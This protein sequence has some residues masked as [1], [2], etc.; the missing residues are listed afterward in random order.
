MKSSVVSLLDKQ[1]IGRRGAVFPEQVCQAETWRRAIRANVGE[2]LRWR[3]GRSA[4][5]QIVRDLVNHIQKFEIYFK[6]NGKPLLSFLGVKW[7]DQILFQ[8][9]PLMAVGG[10]T[11]PQTRKGIRI[12]QDR[13]NSAWPALESGSESEEKSQ[14]LPSAKYSSKCSHAPSH[15][16]FIASSPWRSL[17]TA[18]IL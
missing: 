12:G 16:I 2:S 8:K 9:I 13:G 15:W 3:E 4:A 1:R 17:M 10:G 18:Y 5:G 6:S 7:P 11:R 14:Y